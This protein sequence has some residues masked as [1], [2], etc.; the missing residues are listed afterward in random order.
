MPRPCSRHAKDLDLR[1]AGRGDIEDLEIVEVGQENDT[2][3]DSNQTAMAS[4]P[5]AMASN[6]IAMTSNPIAMASK[7]KQELEFVMLVQRCIT[8]FG[9]SL[10]SSD[11]QKWDGPLV[12]KPCRNGLCCVF[13]LCPSG[14]DDRWQGPGE[15]RIASLR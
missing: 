3:L 5:I 15:P 4:N 1:A 11:L 12:V 2:T 7:S 13:Y 8:F 10:L 6:L 14:G 9:G